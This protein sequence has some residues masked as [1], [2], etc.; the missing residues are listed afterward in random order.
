[1]T[2]RLA[3]ITWSGI[4]LVA[5][6]C[7]CGRRPHLQGNTGT[8]Q[9]ASSIDF[10]NE[11]VG[12]V[13]TLTGQTV[14]TNA[15]GGILSITGDA[16]ITGTNAGD[17]VLQTNLPPTVPPGGAVTATLQFAPSDGGARS[18]TL[19]LPT[20]SGAVSIPL[21]GNGIDVKLCPQPAS[22][23]FGNVQ[24]KGTPVTQTLQ[25]VNCGKS[26]AN[27]QYLSPLVAGTNASDY[28]VTDPSTSQAPQGTSLQPGDSVTLSVAFSP[29]QMGPSSADLPFLPCTGC[30]AQQV[31][32]NGVGVDGVLTFTPNPVT[33]GQVQP[34]N[35]VTVQITGTNTGT[36]NLN[37]VGLTTQTGDPA[38][39]IAAAPTLPVALTPGQTFT[40]T[41]QYAPTNANGDQDTLVGVFTVADPAV[42]Q[43]PAN[44][45]LNG[46]A[47]AGPCNLAINPRSVSFG[48]VTVGKSAT[49]GVVLQNTGTGTCHVANVALASGTDPYFA[50][51]SPPASIAIPAS[52]TATIQVSFAPTSANAPTLRK[53]TLEFASDDP[54]NG[55][56][57]VPLVGS[58]QNTFYAG[59]WPKWHRD[60]GNT[61][62]SNANTAA[63]TNHVQWKLSLGAPP[64]NSWGQ[65]T[66]I[67][68]PVLAADDTV[69]QLGFAPS[70][71]TNGNLYA[72]NHTTGQIVWQTPVTG[73]ENSAQES[74]PT[75]LSN[76]NIFL[77]TGGEQHNVPQ[78]YQISPSG[79]VL[80]STAN[81]D[82]G[83][84]SCPGLGYDGTL[85]EA[86]DDLKAIVAYTNTTSGT[87]TIKWTGALGCATSDWN[88]WLESFS[89]AIGPDGSSYW[90]AG[91]DAMA[92]NPSGTM[93]W[94]PV[95][96]VGTAKPAGKDK[97]SPAFDGTNLY[98]VAATSTSTA[99]GGT[100]FNLNPANG[101]PVWQFAFASVA[102][103]PNAIDYGMSSPTIGADGTIVV[104]AAD[105]VYGVSPAGA[106]VW[107]I[108]VASGVLSSA[109]IGGDNTGFI[110]TEDGRLLAF[111]AG[112]G[113]LKWTFQAGG[114]INSSPAIGTDGTVYFMADDGYLYALR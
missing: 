16:E 82:D 49:K 31:N 89:G 99:V 51:V 35:S 80:W 63:T 32:L 59:S 36:E 60:N 1:M 55:T 19:T 7:Q 2:F 44:D 39:S 56:A 113:T 43:R 52:T 77:M 106:Q 68:S 30:T 75:V 79:S 18:A 102:P 64:K 100:L 83:Y 94:A 9:G 69:Y 62:L 46:N 25:I 15:G 54:N 108:P 58:I 4:A 17:F 85:Y 12:L 6:G 10:G 27:V 48:Y 87:P 47:P 20:D 34:G 57:S 21:T 109:A 84:D 3:W 98:V 11:Q 91:G 95:S 105:G 86:D 13:K 40:I 90:S 93:L 66:Y 53:G 41:I 111:D 71:Q 78:F 26:Q 96:L 114:A 29:A 14:L 67:M 81:S 72:V 50:L 42:G 70:G 101:Q 88:C 37:V 65:A 97:A 104:G 22:L 92:M 73:P 61:G 107:K 112:S 33:F 38:F 23:D 45:P 5:V 8:P 76:G 24:V 110:G 28:T 74:T 103:N